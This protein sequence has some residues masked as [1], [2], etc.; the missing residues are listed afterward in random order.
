MNQQDE[1]WS[2]YWENEGTDGEVF[3]NNEG[4][5]HPFLAKYWQ[6][7]F[8]ALHPT[9]KVLDIA[10]GAGSIFSDLPDDHG[11]ELH[12][13]DISSQALELLRQRIPTTTTHVCPATN[14][15]LADA[16]FDFV[17]SQFG[18][19]YAGVEAFIEASRLVKVGGSLSL[20]CHKRNGYIDGR[21]QKMLDSAQIAKYSNF[22]AGA[23]ALITAAYNPQAA[24]EQ[25][26]TDQSIEKIQANFDGSRK[27]L[28]NSIKSSPEGVHAHLY[29]GFK[30]LFDRRQAYDLIDI[31]RWLEDMSVDIDRNIMRLTEMCEAALSQADVKRITLKLS[32]YGFV[33]INDRAVI[34]PE[35]EVPVAWAITATKV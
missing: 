27:A 15:P 23:T 14:V 9:A 31:T 32:E 5:R 11:F 26:G 10:A 35:Q 4:G 8:A 25:T 3:V 2:K 17:V 30:Q 22:V 1:N 16:S 13:A 6:Q 28:E 33:D 29:F 34:L 19:E 18:I 20:L 12:A 24:K 7:Q 21:N